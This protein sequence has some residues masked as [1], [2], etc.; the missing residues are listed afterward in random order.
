MTFSNG[1]YNPNPLANPFNTRLGPSNYSL[2]PAGQSYSGNKFNSSCKDL[3]DPT[4]LGQNA[5]DLHVPDAIERPMSLAD[6]QGV[7]DSY[8]ANKTW[9]DR[10]IYT[11][12]SNSLDNNNGLSRK[13]I[14]YWNDANA[15]SKELSDNMSD[16]QKQMMAEINNMFP[17][18]KFEDEN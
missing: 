18:S 17:P 7:L 3:P 15:K 11:L 1:Q 16:E 13:D 9:N 10:D 14:D 4:M 6:I 12:N 5:N 2:N 8:A